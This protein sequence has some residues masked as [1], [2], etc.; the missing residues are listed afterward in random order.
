M[1]P[2]HSASDND[3]L[4]N[5]LHHLSLQL[6]EL[7]LSVPLAVRNQRST[8]IPLG[9]CHAL[10]KRFQQ[11]SP[12]GNA[13]EGGPPIHSSAKEP[14][15][16]LLG[17]A[18]SPRAGSIQSGKRPHPQEYHPQYGH[19]LARTVKGRDREGIQEARRYVNHNRMGRGQSQAGPSDEHRSRLLRGVQPLVSHKA[20]IENNRRIAEELQDELR[21]QKF[22]GDI[23]VAERMQA[24]HY[25]ERCFLW[26]DFDPLGERKAYTGGDRELAE[27]L[28]AEFNDEHYSR[29]Q[30][31]TVQIESDEKLAEKLTVEW[32]AELRS[33]LRRDP[34]TPPTRIEKD[35]TTIQTG[36]ERRRAPQSQRL[37]ASCKNRLNARE[38]PPNRQRASARHQRE[39]CV[40]C[41]EP[42][43]CFKLCPQSCDHV[44]CIPCVQSGFFHGILV[45]RG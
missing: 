23:L 10:A 35:R 33:N 31:R 14:R 43:R 37:S 24:H 39:V 34:A 8:L 7:S 15:T 38:E 12:L 17:A 41:M 28:Q 3:S 26:H 16:S 45:S 9:A 42:N 32:D 29:L 6:E 18:P 1:R 4:G 30:W 27:E 2:D 25:A 5:Q 13:S 20:Q 22:E 21:T 40:V 36:Q 19:Q 11:P 44:Y